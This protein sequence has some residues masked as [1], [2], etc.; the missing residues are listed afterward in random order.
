M[1]EP[2]RVVGLFGNRSLQHITEYRIANVGGFRGNAKV[3]GPPMSQGSVGAV[4]VLG[5]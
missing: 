1:R 2:Q 3:S 5:A 4:I